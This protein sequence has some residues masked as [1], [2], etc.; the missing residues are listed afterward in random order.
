MGT[1]M[2]VGMDIEMNAYAETVTGLETEDM[3]L[4][5]G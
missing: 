1:D 2:N 4:D 5:I 3:D